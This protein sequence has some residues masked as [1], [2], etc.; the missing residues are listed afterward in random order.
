MDEDDRLLQ[1]K[2][3]LAPSTTSKIDIR[4]PSYTSSHNSRR[5][6]ETD[7]LFQKANHGAGRLV[8]DIGDRSNYA[9]STFYPEYCQNEQSLS[10]TLDALHEQAVKLT[11]LRTFGTEMLDKFSIL[12]ST[13][14][15]DFD[16]ILEKLQK[17]KEPSSE[18]EQFLSKIESLHRILAESRQKLAKISE[19]VTALENESQSV[20][21]TKAY[22]WGTT[23]LVLVLAVFLYKHM[24]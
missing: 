1:D 2:Q 7:P 21:T 6:L 10:S 19:D 16:K 13:S 23:M 4:R 17:W 24:F 18:I 5:S 3:L 14:H 11:E 12:E 15:S 22:I 9:L 8:D 20:N